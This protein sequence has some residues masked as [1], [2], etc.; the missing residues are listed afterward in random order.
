MDEFETLF[1]EFDRRYALGMVE[2]IRR[3]TIAE[4]LSV[5]SYTITW[6]GGE[7]RDQVP[8]VA[9]IV[10]QVGDVVRVSLVANFPT[11]VDCLT[12]HPP[13]LS[14]AAPTVTTTSGSYVALGGGTPQVTLD[15]VAGQTVE[16]VITARLS[17]STAGGFAAVMSFAVFGVESNSPSDAD[18]IESN[19]AQGVTATKTSVYVATV[20]GEHTFAARYR[21]INAVTGTYSDRRILVKP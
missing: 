2:R 3:A 14:D 6:P 20:T 19:L 7:Q 8:C 11:I 13:V 18:S 17:S 4:A 5:N 9:G 21:V 1:E 16:V 15:L 12:S 10:P